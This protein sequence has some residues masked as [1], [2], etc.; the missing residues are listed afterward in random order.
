MASLP[1]A[2]ATRR[3]G[4][5]PAEPVYRPAGSG[6]FCQ[7]GLRWANDSH[8]LGPPDGVLTRRRGLPRHAS[9]GAILP[10]PRNE[11]KI[12]DV[13][14]LPP[15]RGRVRSAFARRHYGYPAFRTHGLQAAEF[16]CTVTSAFSRWTSRR[17]GQSIQERFAVVI[18]TET[19]SR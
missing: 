2:A 10:R 18:Y 11:S 12:G 15:R 6:Q 8:D 4:S 14:L 5:G 16:R 13:F 7:R 17:D 19:G 3:P 1:F 9:G